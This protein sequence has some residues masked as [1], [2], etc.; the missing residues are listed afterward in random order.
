[1]SQHTRTAVREWLTYADLSAETGVP[2]K[3]LQRW[4]Y[5][6]KGPR[7]HHFGRHVRFA[8]EDVNAWTDGLADDSPNGVA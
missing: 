5:T 1:M 6:G 2:V 7:V 3:T 8:R 4:V